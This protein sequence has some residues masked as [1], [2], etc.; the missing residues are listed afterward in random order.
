MTLEKEKHFVRGA[1]WLAVAK[2]W[3]VVSAYVIYSVLSRILQ[4]GEFGVYGLVVNLVS[5]FNLVM[6]TGTVQSVSRFVSLGEPE[7]VK[8]GALKIMGLF[9]LALSAV[10]FVLA[11]WVAGLLRDPSLTFPFRLSSLIIIFYSLYAVFIGFLNGKKEFFKQGLF[12][13]SYSTLRVV[14]IAGLAYLTASVNGAVAGFVTAAFVIVIAAFL[15]LGRGES[16]GGFSIR[17]FV[18][19]G[20]VLVGF[21]LVANGMMNLDLFLIKALSPLERSSE[22]AGFY[23]ASLTIARVPYM[24]LQALNLAVFPVV[25][26]SHTLQ[27]SEETTRFIEKSLSGCFLI[28]FLAAVL[29]SGDAPGTLTLIY[30]ARYLEGAGALSILAWAYLFFALFTLSSTV[31]AGLGKASVALAVALGA[32]FMEALFSFGL[33]PSWGLSGG[34]VSACLAFAFG[35]FANLIYLFRGK[36]LSFSWRKVIP[37]VLGGIVLVIVS[38]AV[39]ARGFALLGKDLVLTLLYVGMLW[40]FQIVSPKAA[41]QFVAKR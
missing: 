40:F 4:P 29:V 30:P 10:Y 12:D 23:T 19:F 20:S 39:P 18:G 24:L 26:E 35:F 13:M 41:F 9:G 25:S 32:I 16:G 3:F 34:A 31:I 11:G 27:K 8:R 17:Q 38:L 14:L 2:S 7:K 5:I 6:V 37:V 21:Y 22:A 33:I 36:F 15:L 1:L 28:A